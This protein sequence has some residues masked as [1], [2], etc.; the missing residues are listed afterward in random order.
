MVES[1]PP[2]PRNLRRA[3]HRILWAPR[4]RFDSFKDVGG[5]SSPPWVESP[6]LIRAR[7]APCFS[8]QLPEFG[9]PN[10]FPFF[11]IS[12][13]RSPDRPYDPYFEHFAR[14]IRRSQ[15]ICESIT[16]ALQLEKSPTIQPLSRV[17]ALLDPLASSLIPR[18]RSSPEPASRKEPPHCSHR[19]CKS[20]GIVSTD[21]GAGPLFALACHFTAYSR[22]DLTRKA[23][24]N[25]RNDQSGHPRISR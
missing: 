11:P 12:P 1:P 22:P 2:I 6:P 10:P 23:D 9:L 4:R 7:E 15:S 8:P 20:D 13:D 18:P 17:P 3:V 25:V 5:D 16:K 19:G 21:I 14:T 24:R